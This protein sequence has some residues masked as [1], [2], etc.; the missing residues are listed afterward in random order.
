MQ[1][2]TKKIFLIIASLIVTLMF[3]R[4]AFGSEGVLQRLGENAMLP[5]SNTYAKYSRYQQLNIQY[6]W[7]AD[8]IAP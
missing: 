2:L 4:Y 8:Y 1:N 3:Y 6:T 7:Q 5:I